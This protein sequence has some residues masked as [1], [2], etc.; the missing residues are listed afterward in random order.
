[1]LN[2]LFRKKQP[3]VSIIQACSLVDIIKE[4]D[5][6]FK[7]LECEFSYL[8]FDEML[9]L[10]RLPTGYEFVHH[11]EYGQNA[12]ADRVWKDRVIGNIDFFLS[13][14]MKKNALA[15]GE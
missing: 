13:R 2:F 9:V 7:E 11:K 3:P 12:L 5:D 10:R 14:I 1:M 6:F 4:T 15:D 8:L